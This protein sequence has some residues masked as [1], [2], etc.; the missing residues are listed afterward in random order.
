MMMAG[1]GG[2]GGGDGDNGDSKHLNTDIKMTRESRFCHEPSSNI[3]FCQIFLYLF[4]CCLS[5]ILECLNF[6]DLAT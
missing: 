4:I 2:G 6:I 3:L 1:G 5:W